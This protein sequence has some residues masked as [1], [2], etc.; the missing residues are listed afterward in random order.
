MCAGWIAATIFRHVSKGLAHANAKVPAAF[1]LRL[2][3]K[4]ETAATLPGANLRLMDLA[5]SCVN[6]LGFDLLRP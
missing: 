3:V 5:L 2:N 1:Y 6:E 4:Q